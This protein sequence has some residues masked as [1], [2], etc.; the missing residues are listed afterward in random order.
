[1]DRRTAQHHR[2][3]VEVQSHDDVLAAP[4]QRGHVGDG[5][6]EALP[7]GP[8]SQGGHVGVGQGGQLLR[9]VGHAVMAQALRAVSSRY[10]H[11]MCDDSAISPSPSCAMS[12]SSWADPLGVVAEVAVRRDAQHMRSL[13]AVRN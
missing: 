5:R 3:P 12:L 4:G 7:A 1:M 11:S 6:A 8:L 9:G 2:L 13:P 10:S